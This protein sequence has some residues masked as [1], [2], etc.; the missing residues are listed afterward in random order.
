[1][2]RPPA[3]KCL[4]LESRPGGDTGDALLAAGQTVHA[5][6]RNPMSPHAKALEAQG[7]RLAQGD[8]ADLRSLVAAMQSVSRV[9]SV[10]N[11]WVLGLHEEMRFGVHVIQAAMEAGH[12]P[13]IVYSW[14]FQHP[15]IAQ[16][17][18]YSMVGSVET[19]DT[20]CRR[21]EQRMQQSIPHI[22]ALKWGIRLLHPQMAALLRWLGRYEA[23]PWSCGIRNVRNMACDNLAQ[24]PPVSPTP[25]SCGPMDPHPVRR[26]RTGPA[27]SEE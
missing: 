1:M 3:E 19:A 26:Q 16:G 6:T 11:F 24:R 20:L 10:Q 8:L 15:H 9:F 17:R 4:R 23:K 21:W 13:H 22:P 12:R 2:R 7:A 5:F 27:T 18:S 14:A 25:F